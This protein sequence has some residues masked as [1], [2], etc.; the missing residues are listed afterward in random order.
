MP[1]GKE[2]SPIV[3]YVVAATGFGQRE[4]WE[5][6]QRVSEEHYARIFQAAWQWDRKGAPEAN[7][8]PIEPEANHQLISIVGTERL[9]RLIAATRTAPATA[10]S[11]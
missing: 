11:T 6:L 3:K 4:A 9:T 2:L 5:L 10:A 7:D 1:N 8:Q